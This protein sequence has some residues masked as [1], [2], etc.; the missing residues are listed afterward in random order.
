[1][2]EVVER[3][4]ALEE[5]LKKLAYAQFNT[6]LSL[7]E[8]ADE[9]RE[10][11]EEM[12]AWRERSEAEMRA[13]KEEMH[14]F[15]DEMRAFKDE[16]RRDREN[17]VKRLGTIVEDL[18]HPNIPR[19]AREHF[20]AT[21]IELLAIRVRV[22]HPARRGSEREFDTLCL[23][24]G[25]FLVVEA[26]AVLRPEYY[27]EW[28]Q[29]LRSGELYEYLEPKFPDLRERRLIPVFASFHIPESDVAYLTRQRVYAMALGED[30]MRLLNADRIPSSLAGSA[31][32]NQ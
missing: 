19:I 16:M 27:R 30:T 17:L 11:K 4:D 2:A 5:A 13:F 6:Q 1:M 3:V 18:V 28:V 23:W 25:H 8:L 21:E 14:A 32:S 31:S 22:R 10:F 12:R 29:F 9:M 20:G 7:Q 26:K 24:P 15:K